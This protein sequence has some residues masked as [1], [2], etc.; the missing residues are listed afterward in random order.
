MPSV[1][2]GPGKSAESA[3]ALLN[4]DQAA[5]EIIKDPGRDYQ[6]EKNPDFPHASAIQA[7]WDASMSAY[8]TH[9]ST[10]ERQLF[11]ACAAHLNVAIT[12]MEIGYR[13]KISQPSAA[14][15]QSAQT[16]FDEA[17]GE[18]AQCTVAIKL[19][20]SEVGSSANKPQ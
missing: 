11:P 18:V 17:P 3:Q 14:A 12:D 10:E 2:A 7:Q 16:R 4:L 5:Q 9:L 20:Q 15:Q 1:C 19:A 13:I 6:K 8:G